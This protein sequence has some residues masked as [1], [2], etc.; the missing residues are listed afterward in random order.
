[1]PT[2]GLRRARGL[3]LRAVYSRRVAAAIGVVLTT[4]FVALRLFEFGW[5]SRWSDGLGLVIGATGIALLLAA[6]GGRR[7]DWVDPTF[8]GAGG[9]TRRRR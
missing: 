3:L 2:A 8:L 6:L 7:P 4:G 5:E 9:E 1:M